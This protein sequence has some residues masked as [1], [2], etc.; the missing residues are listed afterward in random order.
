LISGSCEP[1][2]AIRYVWGDPE[3]L[4]SRA[5]RTAAPAAIAR[6]RMRSFDGAST[7]EYLH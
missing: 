7:W 1:E 5:E 6:Y 3:S 4:D 2:A